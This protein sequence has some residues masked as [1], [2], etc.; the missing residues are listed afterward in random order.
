MNRDH[1][2]Q[3]VEKYHSPAGR[4]NYYP[5]ISAWKSNLS[6]DEW[7]GEINSQDGEID[8]YIHIPFCS[9]FC[10]FCGCNVKIAQSRETISKYLD[11]MAKEFSRYNLETNRVKNIFIG[12]GTPNALTKDEFEY[13]FNSLGLFGS[14]NISMEADPRFINKETFLYLKERGL[15]SLS[16]GVQDFDPEVLNI[17]GRPTDLVQLNKNFDFMASLNLDNISID[18]LYG[19]AKQGKNSLAPFKE[20]L[21]KKILTGVSL[22]PFANVPWF[23]DFYPL[24]EEQKPNFIK[25]YEHYYALS[26]ILEEAG[27]QTISFGHFCKNGS[28]IEKSYS[29]GNLRRSIMGHGIQR[30]ETLIGLGVSAISTTRD[31]LKQNYKIFE[32]YLFQDNGFEKG[33]RRSD[34]ETN[35]E[36]IFELLSTKQ[37]L[38]EFPNDLEHLIEDQLIKLDGNQVIITDIGR[39]F[40]QHIAK[41][42][43]NSFVK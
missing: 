9:N 6:E 16:L 5:R 29:N 42:F 24:W 2:F 15:N 40:V 43:E 37:S 17:I 41:S 34:E 4:Y 8:L 33:H 35:L 1:F 12:G 25:K 27:F 30:S 31:S 13:L 26:E 38:E 22:Y 20:L 23:Q 36:N 32:N 21:N 28:S 19:L 14:Y 18:L 10:H 7:F 39:H 3:L 11:K